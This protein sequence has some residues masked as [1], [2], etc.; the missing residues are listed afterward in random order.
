M[1]KKLVWE[2]LIAIAGTNFKKEY[3]ETANLNVE[4]FLKNLLFHAYNNVPYY[5]NVLR[6]AGA[7]KNGKVCLANFEKIPILTKEIIRRRTDELISRDYKKRKWFYN[8]SGGST[9]EP[10]KLIQDRLSKKWNMAT[11][12]HYYEDIIGV[13]E[14]FAKKV[15]LWGA[16]RD[17]FG[18]GIELKKV[19]NNALSNTVVLDSMSMTETDMR[20]FVRVINSYRPEIIRGYAGSLFELC[21]FVERKQLSI[22][23]P[24]VVVS[25]AETLHGI[26]RKKIESVFGAK[27]YDF[28]GS[29]EVDGIA[30]ECKYSLLHMF[31][32][33]NYIEVLDRYNKRVK[34][35]E[36]GRIIITTL[37]NFSMPLIRYEIGDM[38]VLGPQKCK[39]GSPLPTLRKVTGRRIDYFLREDGKIIYGGYFIELF[40]GKDWVKA[41]K[42]IQEDYKRLRILIV[43]KDRIVDERQKREMEEKIE[44]V[45]G[46][47]CKVKWEVVD[48]I[49]KTKTGKYLHVQS[50]L[51]E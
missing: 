31:M 13:D 23:S 37:H 7:I 14:L 48:E 47:G 6:K 10:I 4:V 8:T 27:V 46:K 9:G 45:M 12:R 42:V 20:C 49:P 11:S 33:N 24:K 29:R 25:S 43:L 19:I 36:D 22:H 26:M 34:E 41:F 35:S 38:A 39:C 44:L 15:L 17:V 30:G 16:R 32:F 21:K 28:Y 51:K 18:R 40:W 50:L 5:H 1:L 3:E 2:L